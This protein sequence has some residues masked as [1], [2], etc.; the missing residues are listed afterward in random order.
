MRSRDD[1]SSSTILVL[2]ERVGGFCS[3]P[4]CRCTTTGPNQIHSKS[5]RVG[6]AAHIC[7]AAPG[8]PRY[9]PSMTSEERSSASNGIWLC[10]NCAHRI[11]V[12]IQR[13]S[14]EAL[15]GW[16]VQAEGLAD[17]LLGKVWSTFPDESIEQSSP[18]FIC[19]HCHTGFSRGQSVCKGCLGQI[20]EG[21]TREERQWAIF[22][23]AM[24]AIVPILLIYDRFDVKLFH[25]GGCDRS[26]TR[27]HSRGVG[28]FDSVVRSLVRRETQEKK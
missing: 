16:K 2:R 26:C 6:I 23:G 24:I 11:D 13:F 14:I 5:T 4:D 12:D 8:G 21:A 22:L 19:P 1:F 9:D 20:V 18:P 7:A 10:A 27:I 25:A 3:N 15:M 28:F 17:Q